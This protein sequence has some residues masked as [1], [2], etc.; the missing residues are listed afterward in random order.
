MAQAANGVATQ[1]PKTFF[2]WVCGEGWQGW[3]P[4][5]APE[6]PLTISL[7]M[8]VNESCNDSHTIGWTKMLV[9]MFTVVSFVLCCSLGLARLLKARIPTTPLSRLTNLP[10]FELNE[11]ALDT[12][13]K[14]PSRRLHYTLGP[15]GSSGASL[16]GLGRSAWGLVFSLLLSSC[17]GHLTKGSWVSLDVAIA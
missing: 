17:P 12:V 5:K 14:E 8:G 4:L 2:F 3:T 7:Q 11:D 10:A 15:L 6:P 16:V 9:C 1:P 13:Y